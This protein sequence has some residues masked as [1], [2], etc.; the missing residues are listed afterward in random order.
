[1]K[2]PWRKD[3][4]RSVLGWA[5]LVP[6]AVA[7]GQAV[8]VSRVE[9][10]AVAQV[11]ITLI[12]ET[13]ASLPLKVYRRDDDGRQEAPDHPLARVLR[14][15]N[16]WQT[17]MGQMVAAMLTHG[18]AYSRITLDGRGAVA[19]LVPLQ[20]EAVNPVRLVNGS[21]AYDVTAPR[22]RERLLAD[23][24]LHFRWRSKDGVRGL[25]PIQIARETF[26]NALAEVEFQG[27]MWRNGA[28]PSAVLQHPGRLGA[29]AHERLK[30][31]FVQNFGGTW[32]AGRVLVCEEGMKLEPW[33]LSAKDA[34]FIAARKLTAED[35]CRAFNVPPPVA[36]I[37]DHATYS[38]IS[39]QLKSF[40]RLTIRPWL[41][42]LEQTITNKLLSEAGRRQFFIEHSV[43]GLLRAD[44]KD[45]YEAYRTGREWG[46]LSPNDIR[47]LENM[48]PIS[49]GDIYTSPLNMAPLGSGGTSDA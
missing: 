23:E 7:S 38:N 32:N 13:C 14:Q 4:K 20:P 11:C 34:E 10:I 48:P 22:G 26:G 43:E 2:W 40:V 18:N 17:A 46:W 45:R 28:R 25:S 31:S 29:E 36:H 39:E 8:T 42:R 21:I 15:P 30:T 5:N 27:S 16:G 33:S 44:T 35:V 49:S 3:E 41:V 6:H 9:G 12:A 24:V 19:A 1:M 47:K 37:L